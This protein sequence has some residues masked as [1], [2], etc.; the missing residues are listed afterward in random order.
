MRV[1][2]CPHTTAAAA[3]ATN[4]AAGMKSRRSVAPANGRWGD[5]LAQTR[6]RGHRRRSEHWTVQLR[7]PSASRTRRQRRNMRKSSKIRDLPIGAIPGPGLTILSAFSLIYAGF[8]V[9]LGR[10]DSGLRFHPSGRRGR[11]RHGDITPRPPPHP[12]P[13]RPAP[14]GRPC[15]ARHPRLAPRLPPPPRHPAAWRCHPRCSLL[16]RQRSHRRPACLH[17]HPCPRP[18]LPTMTPCLRVTR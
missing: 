16:H 5:A 3:P 14:E 17:P 13:A 1:R 11:R 4:A 8:A 2:A 18:P 15:W 6:H 12:L 9:V 7:A 10:I